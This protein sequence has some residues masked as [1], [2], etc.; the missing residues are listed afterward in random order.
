MEQ[1]RLRGDLIEVDKILT[2]LDKVDKEK[3][4]PLADGTRMG[5]G[6]RGCRFWFRVAGEDE[7]KNTLM[8]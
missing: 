4:F 5:G 2:A 1:R 8:Q 7:R 6:G 3:L